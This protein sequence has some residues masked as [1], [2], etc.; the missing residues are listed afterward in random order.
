[1]QAYPS[2]R[3]YRSSVREETRRLTIRRCVEAAAELF[4]SNGYAAT[5]IDA[6]AERAG[7]AR[8]TVFTA[9]G[10]KVALLKLAYDW[11]LVGDD[12]R[13]AMAQRPEIRAIAAERRPRVAIR[14]WASH[15]T[16]VAARS[17]PMMLVLRAAA[18]TDAEAA[19][20]HEKA[21]TDARFGAEM[22]VRHL[23][24]IGTL[25]SD[26]DLAHAIDLV[27]GLLDPG[28]YERMVLH[29]AWTPDQFAA[30]LERTWV[31][32]LLAR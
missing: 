7:V 13:V 31:H 24:R 23:E 22:F 32:G 28:L 20:L 25:R 26:L 3:E 18:D 21:V 4:L 12:E 30:L 14:L 19:A 29:G 11:S 5:T 6:V 2:V 10:G 27:W 17:V 15:V 16:V 8:R 1:M 9:V